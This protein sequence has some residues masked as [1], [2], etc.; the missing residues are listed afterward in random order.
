MVYGPLT[1]QLRAKR[2]DIIGHSFGT[3]LALEYAARY[4]EHVNRLV[5]AGTSHNIPAIVDSLCTRLANSDPAAYARAA[6]ATRG[7]KTYWRCDPFEAYPDQRQ[8]AFI[9]HNMF[10]D[11][12]VARVVKEADSANGLGNTGESFR[13]L[14]SN[15]F[16]RYRFVKFSRMRM[17]VLIVAGELDFETPVEEHRALARNLPQATLLV[18]PS[19]GHFTFVEQPVRF[20]RDVSDFLAER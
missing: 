19:S 13:G 20:G 14:L 15:G 17:P 1:L 2:I 11:I 16:A 8:Q 3:I 10:P 18:Y 6:K 9:D 7:S 5:I 4:P 12:R